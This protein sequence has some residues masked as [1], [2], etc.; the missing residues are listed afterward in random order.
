MGPPPSAGRGAPLNPYLTPTTEEG[1][2]LERTQ[3]GLSST[4]EVGDYF[5]QNASTSNGNGTGKAAETKEGSADSKDENVTSPTEPD[6]PAKKGK[7]MFG[8]KFN[9]SFNMK[10]FGTGTSSSEPAKPAIVDEKS[11]DSDSR[12]TKTNEKI[13]EDNFYGSI[14]RIRQTY[15]EQLA[16]SAG[17]LETQ[18]TPSLPNDTPVLKPPASTTILIQ[19]DRPEAG[20]VADL[21]E[22]KVGSLGLQADLIEKVAPMWLAEVL[23]RVR[24]SRFLRLTTVV[25]SRRHSC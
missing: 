10:K 6:T 16:A 20:G 13:F 19:E 12:S 14:Q 11:E 21:F 9:M 1:S 3:T 15:E 23:L 25:M 4:Q 18:I 22:G 17:K 5:G 2:Q 24:V 7:G 8:K